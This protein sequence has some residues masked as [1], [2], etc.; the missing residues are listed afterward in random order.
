MVEMSLLREAA[1]SETSFLKRS[2][3]LFQIDLIGSLEDKVKEKL[4]NQNV[5]KWRFEKLSGPHYFIDQRKS[6]TLISTFELVFLFLGVRWQ[7]LKILKMLSH[8]RLEQD[9][10]LRGNRHFIVICCLIV[11]AQ[12]M[13]LAC[14][15]I[16][17]FKSM[18]TR[19]RS[20]YLLTEA[21]CMESRWVIMH[22][23]VQ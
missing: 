20:T 23:T 8:S 1:D 11:M 3:V 21:E 19:K 2:F 9:L 7:V 6:F 16:R 5:L 13:C 12:K 10:L 15:T 18:R 17:K 4:K 22:S 14:N